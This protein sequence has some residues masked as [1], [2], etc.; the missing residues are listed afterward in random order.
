MCLDK[1][2]CDLDLINVKTMLQF[3]AQWYIVWNRAPLCVNMLIVVAHHRIIRND[4]VT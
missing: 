1:P 4:S 2:Y 3:G